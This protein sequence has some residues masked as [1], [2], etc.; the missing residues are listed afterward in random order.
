MYVGCFRNVKCG[1]PPLDPRLFEVVSR[2]KTENICWQAFS[3][4]RSLS[5]AI[6]FFF[7]SHSKLWLFCWFEFACNFWCWDFV[8]EIKPAGGQE[9]GGGE[10]LSGALGAAWTASDFQLNCYDFK[11]ENAVVNWCQ[12]SFPAGPSG[13]ALCSQLGPVPTSTICLI[14][15]NPNPGL[16]EPPSATLR[17]IFSNCDVLYSVLFFCLLLFTCVL[18]FVFVLLCLILLYPVLSSL[19]LLCHTVPL[20]RWPF[21]CLSWP[22]VSCYGSSP[23]L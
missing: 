23:G 11:A 22:A 16:H 3:F 2:F 10:V 6:V 17:F 12:H 15:T 14:K 7:S 13:L 18:F 19:V 21:K 1:F 5:L 20:R 4:I 9:W 8:S